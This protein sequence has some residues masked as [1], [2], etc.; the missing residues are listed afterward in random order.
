VARLREV[1]EAA[2]YT[3]EGVGEA[4]AT[5]VSTSRDSA[6]LPLYLRLLPETESLSSLIKLFLLDVAVPRAEAA[7]ALA[8]LGLPELEAAGVLIADADMVRAG[9]E[10]VPTGDLIVACDSFLQELVRPDHVLGISPPA[11]VLAALTVRRSVEAA[12][13]VGTGNGIQAL[14]AARHAERVVGVD[15]NPR[16]LRMAAFNALLNGVSGIELRQGSLFEPVADDV[17]DLIVCNPPY[18]ISPESEF[19][20]RDSGLPGDSFCEGVVRSLPRFLREGGFAH[21]LVSWI[22]PAEGDWSEPLRR[23]IADS[24]CDA[25]L[26]RYTTHQPLD[27][28]AGWNRPLRPDPKAYAD[29]LDRWSSHYRRAEIEAISWGVIILRRRSGANWVWAHTPSSQRVTT[30]SEHVLRLFAA[31]DLLSGLS[32]EALLEQRLALVDE[33]RLEQ[34]SRFAADAEVVERTVLRL[35]RGLHFEVGIDSGTVEVLRQVD[36]HRTVRE[37]LDEAS[38]TLPADMSREELDRRALTVLRRLVELGFLVPA[39]PQD[40]TVS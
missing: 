39:P 36:G 9:V 17:F 14:L 40:S 3:A 23:W 29:A 38:G 35:N 16:A 20:Y 15:I 32:D 22:H 33:H 31:Q 28:A 26:L 37:L 4:L 13:D 19:V 8:P 7:R 5:E 30:A 11:K 34:T 2:G 24:G 18:V 25:L 12:L 27:Y 6:E 21:I 10:L 1:L